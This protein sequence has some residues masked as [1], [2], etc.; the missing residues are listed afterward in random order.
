MEIK[1]TLF[2]AM[3]C[4][5]ILL[6]NLSKSEG[7]SEYDPN[8]AYRLLLGPGE[9]KKEYT[10]DPARL[11][12]ILDKVRMGKV[13]VITHSPDML[14]SGDYHLE[15]SSDASSSS[16]AWNSFCEPGW[17]AVREI[18]SMLIKL[19]HEFEPPDRFRS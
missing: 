11:T 12:G 5:D 16:Y 1:L 9:V 13:T 19:A 2:S 7:Y 10:P 3:K 17:E 15:I 14:D 8:A 18:A 6:T 4:Y